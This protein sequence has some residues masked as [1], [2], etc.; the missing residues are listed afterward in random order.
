MPKHWFAWMLLIIILFMEPIGAPIVTVW[1]IGCVMADRN[2]F[3]M[4]EKFEKKG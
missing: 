2:P 1:I 4:G 3:K